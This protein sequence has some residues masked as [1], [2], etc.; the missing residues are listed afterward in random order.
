MS[1]LEVT[2]NYVGG[3]WTESGEG[4]VLDIE[5]PSTGEA[6]GKVS[7]STGEE[8][9]RAVEAARAAFPEWRATPLPQ[10]VSHLFALRELLASNQEEISRTLV[11][12]M[13]KSLPDARAEMKRTLQNIEVACGMP[14][15]QHGDKMI[16]SAAGIDGEVIRLPVGVFA[17]ITPFNFPA[18]APFWFIPYA[19]ATGNT[20]VLK[21]SEQVPLTMELVTRYIDRTDL[22]AGVF[23]LVNGDKAAAVAL[24]ENPGVKGVSFVG[25]SSTCRVVAARC[26]EGGK[27]Y[28][29]MG[30]A[31]NHLVV[32]PDY[33]KMD[34]LVRNMS[35]S[36]FGCAGQRCMASSAIVAVGDE[37]H[38]AVAERFV[39]DSK[40]FIV[41][42]PLDP[43]VADEPM[44]M[45]P[46]ISADAKSF[47]LKMI[48]TGVREG[49]TL[50]LDGRDITIAGREKGH[51]IGPTV[52]TDVE[53]G[54]E[55]HR[56]EIFGPVVVILKA[57]SLDEAI[58]IINEHQYAN[59]CSIYT[60][61]GY[62]ARKFKLEAECGMIGVNVG[63]PAPV[64]FLPFG[65]MNDSMICDIKMQGRAAVDFFTEDKIVVERYWE[66]V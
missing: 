20:F 7:L 44:L 49:A 56:T 6:I 15:L 30:S 53:P 10:R 65:G 2:R 43:A 5:N 51:F 59:A 35:T 54:M 52:F 11:A 28:Q 25:K 3:E 34:Q 62:H 31:K 47:I 17:A 9:D 39:E 40:R 26:V 42:D 60:Q 13:G 55:I 21:P 32:M 18:M 27:R 22:P 33:S 45:G 8:V 64:P 19:I 37:M 63:I 24:V 36:C 46:V 48:E 50:A 58:T 57:D 61:N 12:E 1:D 14:V 41:A 38:R 29:A 4:D 23:N 66:E 16:G